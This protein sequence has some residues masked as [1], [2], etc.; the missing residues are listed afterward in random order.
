[1]RN[2]IRGLARVLLAV[3]TLAATACTA[4]SAAQPA[5]TPQPPLAAQE[6][7]AVPTAGETVENASFDVQFIDMMVPH[8]Q[9]AVEMAHVAEL[10]AQRPELK[11][12]AADVINGQAAEIER[13]RTWRAAWTGSGQ[14]PPM[15]KMPTL[16]VTNGMLGMAGNG[17]DSAPTMNMAKDVEALHTAAEPFDAAFIE[18]MIPHHQSAIEAARLALQQASHPELKDLAAN[19]IDAQLREI[20]QMQVWRTQW[21]GS[22]GAHASPPTQTSRVAGQPEPTMSPMMSEGH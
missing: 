20:G 16:G 2:S 6:T 15:E 13:M 5:P 14:T 12:M 22:V 19:I 1:M 21:Y 3:G 7:T 8:H 11:A 9:G 10:R 18:A 17:M 4:P